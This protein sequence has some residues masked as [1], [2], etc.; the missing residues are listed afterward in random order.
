[1]C[2]L[3][4]RRTGPGG[5][6]LSD[7]TSAFPPG[8]LR[9]K[10]RTSRSRASLLNTVT[11]P[12]PQHNIHRYLVVYFGQNLKKKKYWLG[13]MYSVFLMNRTQTRGVGRKSRQKQ[14]MRFSKCWK[15]EFLAR[16]FGVRLSV[17]WSTY[18]KLNSSS[19]SARS[20][21]RQISNARIYIMYRRSCGRQ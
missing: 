7:W 21:A 19:S 12:K 11:T 4:N 18:K 14:K 17:C 6:W 13:I 15:Y 1:M 5:V 9:T 8:K 16:V 20:R 3:D 10:A 2:Y